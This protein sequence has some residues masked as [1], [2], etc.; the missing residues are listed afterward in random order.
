MMKIERKNVLLRTMYTLAEKKRQE[1]TKRKG[2]DQCEG[3]NE[4][5]RKHRKIAGRKSGG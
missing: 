3:E 1:S 5:G 2:D 4:H